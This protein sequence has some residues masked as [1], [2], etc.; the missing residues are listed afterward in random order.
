MPRDDK[1]AGL[2]QVAEIQSMHV[3]VTEEEALLALADNNNRCGT[4]P[5]NGL[6]SRGP[7]F[8]LTCLAGG[9]NPRSD[10]APAHSEDD[11][12]VALSEPDYRKRLK[13]AASRKPIVG[14][15]SFSKS[16]KLKK[17]GEMKNTL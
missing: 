17:V 11:A 3:D 7:R 16:K 5:S 4:V 14:A 2:F 8:I 15:G 10:D 6:R 1:L 12:C 9:N 13:A